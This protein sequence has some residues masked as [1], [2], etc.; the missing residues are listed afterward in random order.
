MPHLLPSRRELGHS[1]GVQLVVLELQARYVLGAASFAK[2]QAQD[3]EQLYNQ[4][5]VLNTGTVNQRLRFIAFAADFKGPA[6]AIALLRQLRDDM[7][8]YQVQPTDDQ[9]KT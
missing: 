8:K 9:A 5:A 2:S 4:V 3:T 7:R 1:D 6:Q